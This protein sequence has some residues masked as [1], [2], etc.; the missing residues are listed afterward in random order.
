MMLAHPFLLKQ[1]QLFWEGF[2]QVVCLWTFLTIFSEAHLWGQTLMLDKQLQPNSLIYLLMDLDL[3]AEAQ[4]RCDRKGPSTKYSHKGFPSSSFTLDTVQ[5]DK[6][7]SPGYHQTQTHPLDCLTKKYDSFI[8]EE[9]STAL[10]SSGTVLY[11]PASNALQ[12][13]WWFK[14]LTQLHFMH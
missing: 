14:D 12:C 10:E 13:S 5:S 3:W 11:I 4:P 6:C 2:P 7:R 9:S 1:L 8:R